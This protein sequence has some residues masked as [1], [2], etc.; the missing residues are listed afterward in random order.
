MGLGVMG[1][2]SGARECMDGGRQAILTMLNYVGF[3]GTR[4]IPLE[5]TCVA[6]TMMGVCLQRPLVR[7]HVR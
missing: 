3:D 7:T 1:I 2:W 4:S 5:V 6:G